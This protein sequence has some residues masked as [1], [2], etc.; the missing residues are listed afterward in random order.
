MPT[1]DKEKRPEVVIKGTGPK[2]APPKADFSG[3]PP[4]AIKP[5]TTPNPPQQSKPSK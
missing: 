3:K 2:N 5:K 4:G 1:S